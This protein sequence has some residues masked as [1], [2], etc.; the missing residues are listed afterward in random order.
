MIIRYEMSGKDFT[1]E[2]HKNRHYTKGISTAFL[3][4]YTILAFVRQA[5]TISANAGGH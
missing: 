2:L 3:L 4:L 5:T 1:R